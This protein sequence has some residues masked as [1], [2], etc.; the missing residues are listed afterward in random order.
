MNPCRF[1]VAT[2][3]LFPLA[4]D[5]ADS[6]PSPRGATP[7]GRF[8]STTD[9]PQS[10]T[11]HGTALAIDGT[12]VVVGSRIES[13]RFENDGAV[14]ICDF[15]TG[16][17][18]LKLS[19]PLEVARSNFGSAVGISQSNVVVGA[20][21]GGFA[22]LQDAGRVYIYD[23]SS[24]SPAHSQM[25]LQ[26]PTPAANERFGSVVAVSG[27]IVAVGM[28]AGDGCVYLYDL[29]AGNPRI[30]VHT[31]LQ[32]TPAADSFGGALAMDGT[33]LVVASKIDSTA[34]TNAGGVHVY[35]LQGA[36]PPQKIASFYNPAP[37]QFRHF[38][39]AV[40]LSGERLVVGSVGDDGIPGNKGTAYAYDLAS[41]A[42]P[43]VELQN[44]GP[45]TYSGFGS[46]V[47]VSGNRVIVGNSLDDTG[48]TNSGAVCFYDL[49][50]P[51][52]G[53]P[54]TIRVNPSPA[55]D[56]SFGLAVALDGD[57][58]VVS[59]PRDDSR[60]PDG[61]SIYSYDA[62]ATL[63]DP[64]L[65]TLNV[66]GPSTNDRF[67]QSV[68]LTGNLL[69]TGAPGDG[70]GRVYVQ[71]RTAP[72]APPR[73][74]EHPTADGYGGFGES[75]A[76]SGH[77]LVVGAP[78][79]GNFGR[80]FVFDLSAA[81]SDPL[82]VLE[83]PLDERGNFGAAVAIHGSRVIV[84]T[85]YYPGAGNGGIAYCFD[86][87]GAAP[88][89]PVTTLPNPSP[90][91]GD[92][93][94]SSVAMDGALVV[95]GS[96]YDDTGAQNS[97][98]AFLFDLVGETPSIPLQTFWN[99][100][101]SAGDDFGRAVA[102]GGNVV[103]V[104]APGEDSARLDSGTVHLYPSRDSG[105]PLL[106]LLDRSSGSAYYRRFGSSIAI[107]GPLVAV[108]G[109]GLYSESV[110][111]Y[112]LENQHPESPEFSLQGAEHCHSV[113]ISGRTVAA[114]MPESGDVAYRQGAVDIAG[115]SYHP[116][117][118]FDAWLH[119]SG[120]GGTDALPDA[121]PFGEGISN[122]LKFAFNLEP[123]RADYRRLEPGN[124]TA[125]L[126]N[127]QLA[128]SA[129]GPVLRMEYLRRRNSS[130]IYTPK[131]GTDLELWQYQSIPVEPVITEINPDWE[132]AVV[133]M[134][135]DP[136][137]TPRLFGLIDVNLPWQP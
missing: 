25:T 97:G 21:L 80:A 37:S 132:R 11:R 121:E 128:Q 17:V 137:A 117:P 79:S 104:G 56:D 93:F 125:G 15:T 100:R 135:V 47:S 33:R 30:P 76:V 120:L 126:P 18:T 45:A 119:A 23:L 53:T 7:Q 127:I 136:A 10:G 20:P 35:E 42:A 115:L 113:A 131:S 71:D 36:A 103:A 77:L 55:V 114:G 64:P 133:E 39:A 16:K 48:G 122:L 43:P 129:E 24:E 108:A 40:D 41:P 29:A 75:L 124:G 27:N 9:A 46:A 54:V 94:G 63:P 134:P 50:G 67:G 98:A 130:L 4:G 34:G 31:I 118:A 28:P 107:S 6:A 91:P 112:D 3:L 123:G 95:V 65:L 13:G 85:P 84:G 58:A 78:D 81:G 62:S 109:S 73:V 66:A 68:A 1:F 60:V 38:G 14:R 32:P 22:P 70:L 92:M 116:D 102:I 106:E 5:A 90:N 57:R 52:P 8:Y 89:L 26:D 69:I 44:P 88:T 86:L 51:I 19:N 49:A 12:R 111:T 101:P 83:N 2:F 61:G 96:P 72:A 87:A 105:A 59:A 74:F 99:P 110:Q 82:E